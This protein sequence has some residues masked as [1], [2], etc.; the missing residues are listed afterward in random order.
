MFVPLGRFRFGQIQIWA[1]SFQL[2]HCI[3]GLIKPN[4]AHSLRSEQPRAQP[5]PP[6]YQWQIESSCCLL[7]G[8]ILNLTHTT[9]PTVLRLCGHRYYI[10]SFHLIFFSMISPSDG[11]GNRISGGGGGF[12]K[13]AVC[14]SANRS[15]FSD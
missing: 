14:G 7:A 11:E 4:W 5:N 10:A 13:S 6:L 15:I 2:V 9:R 8:P 12:Q 1:H 3:A